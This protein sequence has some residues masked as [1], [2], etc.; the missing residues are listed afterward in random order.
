MKKQTI[1][2]T[3]ASS[4]V[5]KAIAR[6]FLNNGDNVVLNS[7][8]IDKLMQV[9]HELGGSENMA[10]VAGDVSDRI[11][12]IK[13]LATALAKF[14][15]VDVLVN[16]AGLLETKPFFRV[17]EKYL[18]RFLD[19]NLKGTFFTIQGIIPQ[20]LKQRNGIV[21]NIGMPFI[22]VMRE[23][24]RNTAALAPKGAV[25]ALTLQLAA[26][27]GIYN[28]SFNTV[29]PGINI[30]VSGATMEKFSSGMH[31][32]D[33]TGEVQDLATMVYTIAKKDI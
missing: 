26:E 9:S 18:E 21:I 28:I 30:E 31:L 2:I 4:D 3:D 7:L 33:A 11:T 17:D 27:F 14:G 15:S 1:I 8:T 24:A 12:G 19:V 25:H 20:M 22:S 32:N 6:L 13:L 5:G 29:T 10:F 23:A 16:N